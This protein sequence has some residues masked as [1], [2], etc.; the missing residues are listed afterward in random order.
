[1]ETV[2]LKVEYKDHNKVV[3]TNKSGD[4]Y[5]SKSEELRDFLHGQSE[6]AINPKFKVGDTV[7]FLNNNT[8]TKEIVPI[9]T[10]EFRNNI[11]D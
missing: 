3:L 1:M 2:T 5:T 11:N 9:P 4:T 7:Y 10:K 8:P 6:K